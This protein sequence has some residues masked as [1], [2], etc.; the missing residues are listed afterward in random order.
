ASETAIQVVVDELSGTTGGTV[1]LQGSIDGINFTPLTVRD[2]TVRDSVVVVYQTFKPTDT[3]NPQTFI[4]RIT[5]NPVLYYRLSYTGEGTM[6][7]TISGK[8]LS[9]N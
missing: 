2:L 8:L 3:P 6:S 4:W 9:R 5:G 7:A 1:T